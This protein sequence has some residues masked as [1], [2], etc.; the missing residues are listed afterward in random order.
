VGGSIAQ[1]AGDR[2]RV[3]VR[4]LDGQSGAEFSRAGFDRP[5]GELIAARDELA[6]QAALLL[7]D[8]LGEQV[9]V[10]RT[11]SETESVPAWALYQRGEKA[12]KDAEAALE[13]GDIRAAETALD[14]ADQLLSQAELVDAQWAQPSVLRGRIAYR[15]AQL[16]ASSEVHQAVDWIRTGLDH[17]ERALA[18]KPNQAEALQVRGMLKYLHHLLRAEPDPEADRA[19]HREARADLERAVSLDPRLSGAHAILSHLYLGSDPASS[20]LAGRRAFEEDAYV[21]NAQAVLWRLVLG[22]YN[23]EQFTEARRWCE[24]GHRRFGEHHRFTVCQLL[25]LTTDG[26]PADP[27]R[28]W[29]LVA[30]IATLAPPHRADWERLRG[31]MLVA[32]VLARAGKQDSARSVLVRA[33]RQV[34]PEL[35]P[36][37]FLYSLEAYIRTLLGDDDGAI[38]VLRRV[39]AANPTA[40][41][42]TEW[43]WRSLRSNPRYHELLALTGRH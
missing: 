9:N 36:D 4:L 11:R 29:Q 28:A 41:F 22:H 2:L 18:V 34:S 40:A 23:L 32:G 15:R 43:W 37:R 1:I 17:V 38:D 5:A 35:D 13:H 24:E 3:S 39:A 8:W 33:S 7:R 14:R 42:E 25:L 19:L 12:R 21:E 27:D 20:V 10:R 31:E 16:A 30:R 6:K 26:E